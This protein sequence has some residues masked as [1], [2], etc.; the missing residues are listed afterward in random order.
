MIGFDGSI[1]I[2]FWLSESPFNKVS[3]ESNKN[4]H[5]H[6]QID[7]KED[8]EGWKVIL[9]HQ[10]WIWS[11]YRTPL[12]FWNQKQPLENMQSNQVQEDLI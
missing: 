10:K 11:C 7:H 2:P 9:P 5:K 6:K 12:Y 1:E 8:K 3:R 4:L